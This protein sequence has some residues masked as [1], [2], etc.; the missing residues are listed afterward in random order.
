MREFVLS[1]ETAGSKASVDMA[2]V[3]R[4]RDMREL[5][6]S[7]ETAGNKAAVDMHGDVPR[8]ER[9]RARP[10]VGDSWKQGRCR[11]GDGR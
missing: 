6:L 7:W 10:L 4:E 9:E 11:H 8:E 2:T 3:P 1:W 5:G